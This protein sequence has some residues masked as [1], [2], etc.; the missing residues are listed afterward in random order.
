VGEFYPAFRPPYKLG[1]AWNGIYME[2]FA[3][4]IDKQVLFEKGLLQMY[5]LAKLCLISLSDLK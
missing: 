2:V 1:V 5:D 4:I 3:I